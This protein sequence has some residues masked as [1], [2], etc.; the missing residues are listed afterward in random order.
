[1]APPS[2]EASVSGP[3]PNPVQAAPLPRIRRQARKKLDAYGDLQ[4]MEDEPAASA[5]DKP[6][7]TPLADRL[8]AYVPS[9]QQ[10]PGDDRV[11]TS[12]MVRGLAVAFLLLV[13]FSVV[14]Y[15]GIT[16]TLASRL[17]SV[18]VDDMEKGDFLNA[19]QDF[20]RFIAANPEDVRTPKARVFRALARVRQHTGKV[21][22]SWGTALTEAQAMVD[23][24]GQTPEYRD[25][26][27]DLAE[28]I[29]KAAEGLADRSASLA[30]PATLAQAEAAVGLHARVAGQA[31]G[32]LI[33][34]SKI[35]EK[36]EKARAAIL[37]S[38]VRASSL[39]AMDAALRANR[40]ADAYAARDALTR[41]YHDL[42]AD[43]EVVARLV[44]ANDLI[45][46][47]VTFDP[48]ARPGET[49]PHPD[50]L[51][52]PTS[53]ALRLDPTRKPTEPRGPVA[54]AMADGLAVGIDA[55][56]G[57]P[58][59]QVPVGP[60]SPFPPLAI[61]GDS[62]SA[63]VFDARYDEL[64]R[65]DGRTGALAWRQETGGPV[66]DPPLVLGNLVL[67]PMPDGRL[68]QVDLASGE[69]RGTLKLG[70]RLTRTPVADDS[71]QH[72]YQLAEEDCLFVLKLGPPACVAVEYLGHEAGSIPCPPARIARYLVLPENHRLE[73]GRW[74]VFVIDEA[75]TKLKVVQEIPVAGWTRSTPASAGPVA[76]SGTDRGELIAFAIGAY[77]AKAPFTQVARVAAGEAPEGP[78]FGRARS[79]RDFTLA[80]SRTGRYELDLQRGKLATLWTLGEAGPA[81]APPQ[82]V[83]RLLVLTHQHQEGPGTALWGVDPASGE[84]RWRTVLGASWPVPLSESSTGDALNG[85]ASEGQAFS[86][87]ANRLRAGGFAE[88]AL[89]RPGRFRLP[90]GA[91]QRLELD[92][93]TVVVPPLGSSS[94][95]VRDAPASDFRPVALPAPLGAAVAAIGGG[96]LIPGGD[97]R[98]YL[99]D[100][101]GGSSAADPYVPSF[102]RTRPTR[103]RRPVVLG[104]N[105]VAV[106]DSDSTLRRI[107]VDRTTRPRLVATAEARLDSPMAADPA[108]TGASVVVATVDGRIR[109]L[110]AR[111]LGPQGSWPLG[112]PRQLGP[113]VVADHAFVVD[114]DGEVMAFGPDGRRLWS[115]R[116]RDTRPA[117]PPAIRD[118]SAWFVGL[119]GSVQRLSMVDGSTQSSAAIRALPDG[120]P[121]AAGPDLVVPTGPGTLRLLD[122]KALGNPPERPTP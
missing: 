28:D 2:V 55:A 118:G 86:I 96:L 117:G 83:D 1:M 16:R 100:P 59:W 54:Y 80:S 8:R 44:K 76:W 115:S 41:R 58:L 102:D 79:D 121:I 81:L 64:A 116:L 12:P 112:A 10:A 27:M 111:D 78:S 11:F 24:V 91:T 103:W 52:P 34:R 6:A 29:R 87:D 49:E 35:P 48:S 90:P 53:L 69:L 120:G 46:Q 98:L 85:L 110:A 93:L 68:L 37:K 15:R 3:G 63:L 13:V 47:A 40:P 22:A 119:G 14:L 50:P 38:Q 31:A 42:A 107:S 67:Q 18:A 92:G 32:S 94:I 71:A 122:R 17:Y 7:S 70:R 104:G 113:V 95:L 89:P 65:V 99:V 19:I 74:R 43:K 45:R 62:P 60:A 84:V 9:F 23:E 82:A 61:A 36:L 56:T 88:L 101:K 51:G 25:A 109:S 39:A 77:D 30:D 33:G 21:G 72:V 105:A 66:V 5:F 106:A 26:N 75:G 108:S 4:R 73:A 57:A 114:A 20:G 97:G